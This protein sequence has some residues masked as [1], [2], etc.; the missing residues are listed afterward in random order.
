MMYTTCKLCNGEI[1]KAFPQF[2]LLRCK[3]CGFIFYTYSLDASETIDLYDKLYNQQDDYIVFKQQADL[4]LNGQQPHL[5][6]N[7]RKV[8]HILLSN[9]CAS[10]IEIGAGVGVVGNYLT[11][12]N[13]TYAGIELDKVAA[14]HAMNAGVNVVNGSFEGISE[15]GDADAII[16]FEVLEHIDHLKHCMELFC[17]KLKDGQ[18]IGFTVPNFN[19]HYNQTV[20]MQ[21]KRLG[22]VGPPVHVNFFTETSL[23]NILKHYGFEPIYLKARPFPYFIWNKMTTYKKFWLACKGQ[24]KGSTILCV[25]KKTKS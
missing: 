9:K 5:G 23:H 25:A 21:Q 22:Q 1:E 20:E 10:F 6:F 18:F 3:Q 14:G 19:V 16:A 17:D 2:E 24:F 7:R 13:K 8:L 12:K 15:F 11:K 4:L